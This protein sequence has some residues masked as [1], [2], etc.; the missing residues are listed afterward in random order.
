MQLAE[1]LAE[2][3]QASITGDEHVDVTTV[4]YDS[5]R[6]EPGSL[7]CCVVGAQLDGH[8]FARDAVDRGAVALLVERP[9]PLAVPQVITPDTRVA[10]AHAAAA[11][12]GHPSRQLDV[13]G[14][15]GTNGKTTVTH[16]LKNVLDAAGRRAG[17]VGT[18]SGVR[19]TPE[20]PDLQAQLAA[21]RDEGIDSVAMEVS[22]HA[23][24]LHRVDA[25]RFRVAV[26]TNLT[27]D[28]LDFHQSME[29]YFEA[30]ARL[31]DPS[32]ADAGVVNLDSPHGRL[33]RDTAQIPITGYSLDQVEE[34][35]VDRTG[36]RFTWRG[37]RVT[38]PLGGAFNVSNALAA[39]EAALALGLEP[40]SIARGLSLPL[41]V[42]G[43]FEVI[44]EGQPFTVI[45]DYAHTPDGL[46]NV[47][48]SAGELAG[49]S[50][51][52]V[53]FGCGGDRDPSKRA[54]MGEMAARFADRVVLTADNS[55][56]EDTGA[57][58]GTVRQGYERTT[59]RRATDLVVE[60]DRRRAIHIALE[61]AAAGDI[62]VI[63]GK[64]HETTLTIGDDVVDFDDRQVAR[65]ELAR[66]AGGC[67]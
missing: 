33:L 18:L 47:L 52:T 3:E 37:Q 13:I 4:T 5:R 58:I 26:F 59:P 63:A 6:V 43:R 53:V 61:G 25:T 11:L 65:E 23:L 15:T 7:F 12:N 41:V 31:F 16:L 32:F 54:P 55:R 56:G 42:P 24:D 29:A 38:L 19:T 28:H 9:L 48:T 10:I 20:S 40:A 21:W 8:A 67:R 57:I 27:R 36:S 34:L 22:S 64:G 66:I 49:T 17:V 1:L 60:P 2:L 62:V 50:S 39:G 30:K 44:D 51:V 46:Q 45:V 14:V 35:E